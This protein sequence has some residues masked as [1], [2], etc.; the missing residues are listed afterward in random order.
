MTVFISEEGRRNIQRDLQDYLKEVQANTIPR[1]PR[2]DLSTSTAVFL[3]QETQLLPPVRPVTEKL[4][5][6]H[7][8]TDFE[9]WIDAHIFEYHEQH[10]RYPSVIYISSIRKLEYIVEQLE[11]Q[12]ATVRWHEYTFRHGWIAIKL[13]TR[14]MGYNDVFCR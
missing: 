5:Q 8:K 14:I 1:T 3:D 2:V 6:V 12:E 4:P 11:R 13:E 7:Q 10:R 9:G